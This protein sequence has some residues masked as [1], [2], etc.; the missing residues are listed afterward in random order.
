MVN[1]DQG[2]TELHIIYSFQIPA[3]AIGV[4]AGGVT[5]RYNNTA[6]IY[7]PRVTLNHK[8]EMYTD[9]Q[10]HTRIYKSAELRGT[11]LEFANSRQ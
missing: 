9:T 8:K 2:W 1:I 7:I 10:I 4:V 3:C 6:Y 5:F 11:K